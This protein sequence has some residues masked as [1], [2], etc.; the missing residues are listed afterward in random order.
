MSALNSALFWLIFNILAI[1]VLA[2]YSMLEMACVSF[3]KV[4]LQYYVSKGYK[5][6]IWLNEL[7][8]NPSKLFGT[9]LVGV[10]IALVISSECGREFYSALGF[11][12]DWSPITQVIIVVI[13]GELAPMFAAR[14]YPEHVAML[15]IPLIYASARLM[16]PFLYILDKLSQ[17]VNYFIGGR[18]PE[19]NLYLSLEELQHILLEQSEDTSSLSESQEFSAITTNIFAMRAKTA[20]QI[21]VPLKVQN[22]LPAS[23]TVEDVERFLAAGANYVP[24]YHRELN[25]IIGIV[26]PREILRSSE[27]KRAREYCK[28][29]WFVTG[30]TT[31]MQLLKQFRTNNENIAI[32]LDQTGNSVGII[33]IDDVLEELFGSGAYGRTLTSHHHLKNLMLVE[34]TYPGDTTVAELHAQYGVVIDENPEA[35]LSEIMIKHLGHIPEKGESV[36]IS[37]F[38]L[39]AKETGLMGIKTVAISTRAIG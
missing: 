13:L 36:Y 16:T 25:N 31:L 23:A 5:R 35:T 4:R 2:F 12:P 38:D 34:K 22:T 39:T 10:N 14:H 6:A 7:L 37:P 20:L 28:P 3:N 24:L 30:A 21:M 17:L 19:V 15:G 26:Y 1:A 32:I 9:T 27:A 18:N 11:S 8:Q 33:S 29:P